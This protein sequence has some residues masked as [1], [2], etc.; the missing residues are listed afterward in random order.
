MSPSSNPAGQSAEQ[1]LAEYM[2]VELV[3]VSPAL[4]VAEALRRMDGGGASCVVA[5]EDGRPVGILTDTD[6]LRLQARADLAGVTV[7]QV[8]T[9]PV[10]GLGPTKL[11]EPFAQPPQVS[12]PCSLVRVGRKATSC[13]SSSV[14][15]ARSGRY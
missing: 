11:A 7:A 12:R 8:M 13:W 5:V 4:P 15:M 3:A 14:L 6:V 9:T 10:V 1:R 2:H